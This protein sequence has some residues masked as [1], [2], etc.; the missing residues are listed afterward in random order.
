[1]TDKVSAALGDVVESGTGR[2][3]GIGRSD[4]A[5]KTGTT[6]NHSA[7]WFVGFTPDLS[8]SVWMGCADSRRPLLDVAGEGRVY[9]GTIPATTWATFMEAA[10]ERDAGS[11][12]ASAA[13]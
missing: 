8:T 3:A 4:A 7:A 5:G 1:M 11:A 6:D 9:G 13:R 10:L 2:S 12:T